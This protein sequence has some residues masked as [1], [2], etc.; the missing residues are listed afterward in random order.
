MNKPKGRLMPNI[1]FRLMSFSFWWRDRFLNPKKILEEL[2]IGQGQAVLD[3][4]CG[5]GSFT[6]PTAR[7]VG[8][9]GKVY[10]LDIHPLAIKTVEKKPESM[11]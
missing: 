5:P 3:F 7:I 10:A 9:T 8:E 2:D 11:G 4:G 1:G 6:I